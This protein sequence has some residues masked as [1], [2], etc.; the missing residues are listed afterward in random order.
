MFF[1]WIR[2]VPKLSKNPSSTL[3]FN[4]MA[5]RTESGKIAT[6]L[7]R[8][9]QIPLQFPAIYSNS[10]RCK[11]GY[12]KWKGAAAVSTETDLLLGSS[13][14]WEILFDLQQS[15]LCLGSQ[16]GLLRIAQ[17]WVKSRNRPSFAWMY[18]QHNPA[19]DN[20]YFRSDWRF[21]QEAIHQDAHDMGN[22]HLINNI[23]AADHKYILVGDGASFHP[24]ST[25]FIREFSF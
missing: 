5:F 16:F 23:S 12:W 8:I 18:G 25:L 11:N 2:R 7:L 24:T 13:R 20:K 19:R 4:Q 21:L 3:S 10:I 22:G 15:A 6:I 1:V 17:M 14:F 9:M